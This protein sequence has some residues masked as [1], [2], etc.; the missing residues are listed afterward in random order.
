MN[1]IDK[2]ISLYSKLTKR[3]I[4]IV[5]KNKLH[6]HYMPNGSII[7][8]IKGDSENIRGRRANCPSIRDD[9]SADINKADLEDILK[10]FVK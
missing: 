8:G 6:S 7:K 4:T 5:R 10:K 1:I 3:S 2:I 9:I